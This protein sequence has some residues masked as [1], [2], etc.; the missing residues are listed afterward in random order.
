[1]DHKI[2]YT[3]LPN[4]TILNTDYR[5]KKTLAV[6]N[7]SLVYLAF[8]QKRRQTC[9][10]KEFFPTQLVLRDI[11]RLTVLT[12]QPSLKDKFSQAT[13]EFFNEALILKTVRHRN[14]TKYLDHFTA[15]NTGYLASE[16][17]KG[18][19]LEQ[20]IKAEKNISLR[21]FLRN[22][23]IPILDAVAALHQIG[24]IHRDLKPNNIIITKKNQPMLIDFG[25]AVRINDPG[26]KKIFVTPG[27]SPL[28]FY[29]ENSRQGSFSDLY[30]LAATLYYYLCGQ[31][32]PEVTQRLFED[33]LEDIKKYNEI[34]SSQLAK[35]IMRN[36][37]VDSQKRFKSVKRLKRIIYWETFFRR[38][39]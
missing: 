38:K 15:N 2:K 25:S 27:F 23:F 8:D 39:A 20:Y 36:L 34:I 30:S 5:I 4:N 37:A 29:A 6:S 13:A 16:Y 1:M 26:K 31:A 32:P 18:P 7:L 19:T 17:Y 14:I 33:K 22:Y 24:V 28:E 12:K 10:I 21:N 9:V 35:T 3:C 11:D